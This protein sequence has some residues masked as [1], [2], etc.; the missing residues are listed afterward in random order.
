MNE[1]RWFTLGARGSE[2]DGVIVRIYGA[3]EHPSNDIPFI[4][5]RNKES[6]SFL[7]SYS[8]TELQKVL[9]EKIPSLFLQ[10]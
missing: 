4:I 1:P 8:S 2:V 7:N 6:F 9:Q 5:Y 3:M 10:R